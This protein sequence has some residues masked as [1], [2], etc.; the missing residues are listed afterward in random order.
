MECWNKAA[1]DFASASEH[2]QVM[3]SFLWVSPDFVFAPR[4]RK[5]R[6]LFACLD[7]REV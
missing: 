4:V 3:Y 7:S 5:M 2:Y 6:K 1:C